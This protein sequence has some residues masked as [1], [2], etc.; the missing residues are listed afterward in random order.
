MSCLLF[1][2]YLDSLFAE[3]NFSLDLYAFCK[4]KNLLTFSIF[5]VQVVCKSFFHYLASVILK[6]LS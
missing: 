4:I 6:R 2:D 3:R 5:L 1:C